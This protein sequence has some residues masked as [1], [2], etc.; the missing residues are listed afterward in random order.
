MDIDDFIAEN[1]EAWINALDAAGVDNWDGYEHAIEV[2]KETMKEN[3][4][5]P[6]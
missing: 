4:Y 6:K 2:L 1:P 5:D 3:G